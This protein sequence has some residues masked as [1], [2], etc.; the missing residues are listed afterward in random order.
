MLEKDISRTIAGEMKIKP[1]QAEA[2][3]KLTDEGSTVPF[4]SRYRKEATGELDD[5]QVRTV[6]ERTE[7]LRNLVKRQDDILKRIEEQGQLTPDLQAAIEKTHKLQ[8]LE[9]L[10]L[11]YKQ[12]KR[13]RAQMAK[14]KGLE[15]L[16]AA[17]LLQTSSCR[18]AL[19]AAQAFINAEKGIDDAAAALAGARDIVA[20][21]IMERADLRQRFREHLWKT[22]EISTEID[23]KS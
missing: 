14:E 21:T 13:T 6:V 23:G 19:E 22:G 15:P 7:Y 18:T 3:I 16:A 12:K 11:P 10:Y 9:D 1:W 17:M 20:E 4:I 5:E 2:V 8:E